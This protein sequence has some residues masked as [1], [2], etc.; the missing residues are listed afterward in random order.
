[1]A[2]TTILVQGADAAKQPVLVDT[3]TGQSYAMPIYKLAIGAVG[4]DDGVISAVNPLPVTGNDA[5]AISTT[6]FNSRDAA[7][8]AAG[9]TFQGVGEDVSKYGR[10]GVSI[11]SDNATDG[12][13]TME[14]SRDNVT[15]SGPTRTWSDT[16]FAQPHMWNIVEK[17]F[18]IKYVNGTTEA[19]NL[20]IQVQYSSNANILLSHQLNE[21]LLDETEAL[22]VRSVGVAQDPLG[23]YKNT[24]N[25]GLGF[26][27]S[28]LLANGATYDSGVLS[29]V[30]YTQ[31]QTAVLSDVDGTV[32]I[33]F[34]RDSGATDILRTLTVP[35][36]GGSGYQTFGAPAFTPYVRYRFTADETGQSDFYFDTKFLTGSLSGQLLGVDAFIS[37]QMVASLT[38]SVIV[39]K[40]SG[41]SYQNVAIEPVTNALDVSVPRSSFGE[42]AVTNPTPV[43]QVDFI[44]NVN[45]DMVETT[46]TGSGTVTQAD[47]MV[48]VS[49]T[50]ASSSSALV[51]TKTFMK[52]RPGQGAQVRGTAL[53]TAGVANSTQKFGCGDVDDGLFFG[54]N[55]TAFGVLHRLDGFDTWI[56][57]TSWN[58]DKMDGTGGSSNPTGQLLDPTK[59]NVYQISFQWLGFGQLVFSIEDSTS[60]RFIPVHT[61]NYANTAVVPSLTN[62]SFP[63]LWEAI[64]TT[65][66]S[67]VIVKGAS[68]CAQIEGKI[69]YLGPTNAIGF[70]KTAITTALTNVL[71][72]RNKSSYQS[73]TNRTPINILKYSVSVDGNK[74]VE[75]ELVKNATL[76][77]TPSYTDISVNTSVVDYDTA[78]TTV[79]GG[80]IIDFASLAS[81]GSLNQSST[82]N[83]EIILLPGETL[84]LA[85]RATSTTTDATATIR[86]VE[87][88]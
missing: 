50:A 26:S 8:L 48:V 87:D 39:G 85:V 74:P 16:R 49:T 60:G 54:F 51:K 64:N 75:F 36:T 33:D 29:L 76:G 5:N 34:I 9:A 24:L 21:T 86:W 12:V 20:A 59:G 71:T 56:P 7:N 66:T 37:P 15:W 73:I 40:T 43:I 63:I 41:G 30:G 3:I 65:N 11:V 80:T 18:R 4:D 82:E 88:F 22:I 38:R 2:L 31:V 23:N 81:S 17:Y 27:T 35:Y 70:S 62:P 13:L 72:I 6:A 84:T 44:Y 47:S 1:M 69:R 68:C 67:N 28:A 14:V 83:T 55:G 25:N 52:Y 53:F 10:V 78:G 46:V 58:A 61:L 19:I 79:T 42:I 32:V 57:Q 77:G 45:A